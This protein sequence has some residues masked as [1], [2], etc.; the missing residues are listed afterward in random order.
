MRSSWTTQVGPK[1]SDEWPSKRQKRKRWSEVGVTEV[2][3]MWLQ[4]KEDKDC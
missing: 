4:A 1:S 3:V 2:G